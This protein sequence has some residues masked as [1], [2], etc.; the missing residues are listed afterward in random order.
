MKYDKVQRNVPQLLSLTGFSVEDFEYLLP[1]FKS[2]WDEH[3]SLFTLEGKPRQRISY[4]RKSSNLPMP[5]D[6]LL[7]ILSY[8]KN[9]PLQEYHGATFGLTQPQCNVWI[10]LL[11]MILEKTLRNLQQLPDGNGQRMYQKLRNI[12]D[13]FLDGTER[14]VQRP[15]ADDVQKSRYSGKKNAY[16]KE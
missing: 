9:N 5:G 12:Q 3:Y 16:R 4:N 11:S 6:K 14:P 15:Q 2:E 10:H 8:L 13:V 7:F 1:I